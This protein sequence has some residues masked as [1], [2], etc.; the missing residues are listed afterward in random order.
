MTKLSILICTMPGR[1]EFLSRLMKILEPQTDGKSVEILTDGDGG[2]I[3]EKR[4]RLISRA[5][6]AY[7]VFVD[8]DDLVSKRYVELV[9]PAIDGGYDCCELRGM[10]YQD[11]NMIKPF[12]HSNIYSTYHEDRAAYYRFP[13]H[14]NP[15]KT[16]IARQIGF[17]AKNFSEDTDFAIRLKNSGLIKTQYPCGEIL[18]FYYFRT[19]K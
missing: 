16:E 6:G 18:Y 9:M 13:N 12:I 8:D 7:C 19:R 10:Y 5:S 17:P 1:E 15:M 4:N 3:G 14:L 11:G 2:T